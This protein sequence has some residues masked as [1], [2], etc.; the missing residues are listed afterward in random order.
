MYDDGDAVGVTSENVIAEV[1]GV[2]DHV[3]V[4]Q[5]NKILKNIL[6]LLNFIDNFPCMYHLR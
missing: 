6:L 2:E 4:E 3:R 1:L 5:L